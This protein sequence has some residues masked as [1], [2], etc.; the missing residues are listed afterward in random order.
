VFHNVTVISTFLAI[1]IIN[2]NNKNSNNI[3]NIIYN[4]HTFCETVSYKSHQT[5][6]HKL[7]K[8]RRSVLLLLPHI[9]CCIPDRNP[10]IIQATIY[11]ITPETNVKR[12]FFLFPIIHIKPT[13]ARASRFLFVTLLHG[14]WCT[15]EFQSWCQTIPS[16]TINK[17][18]WSGSSRAIDSTQIC[19]PMTHK[20]M[21]PVAYPE[22]QKR[23]SK[24][25]DETS[26]IGC[27]QIASTEL[28]E[29]CETLVC[30]NFSTSFTAIVSTLG[31][32][33][34]HDAVASLRDVGSSTANHH[35]ASP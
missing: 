14:V 8:L 23:I 18:T 34:L 21:V 25:I 4:Q 27:A 12:I 9:A 35:V 30:N 32:C 13:T 28:G 11:S 20:S 29:V 33:R 17:V 24:S 22:L 19:M 26:L 2:I 10:N 5:S 1:R 31:R 3:K 6:F 16:V 7:L 15:Q